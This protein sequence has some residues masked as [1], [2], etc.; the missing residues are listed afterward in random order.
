MIHYIRITRCLRLWCCTILETTFQYFLPFILLHGKSKMNKKTSIFHTAFYVLLLICVGN[1]LD[2]NL[3]FDVLCINKRFWLL[4]WC[5]WRK[6]MGQDSKTICADS[7]K[8]R[9][10]GWVKKWASLYQ[11][12]APNTWHASI[13]R[14][15]SWGRSRG[16]SSPDSL[17]F[18][19]CET[20]RR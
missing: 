7:G 12:G 6:R 13:L 2:Y 17:A 19:A 4:E 10:S 14:K 9:S 3:C 11:S 18:W 8:Y 16:R 5:C 1:V 20:P 15:E